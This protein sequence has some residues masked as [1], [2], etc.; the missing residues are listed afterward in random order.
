MSGKSTAVATKPLTQKQ[1]EARSKQAF[2]LERSIKKAAVLAHASWWALAELLYKFHEGGYWTD[3]GYDSLDEFLAQPEIGISRAQFFKQSKVWRDLVVVKKIKP[4]ELEALEPAK[5][6]EV[7]PAIM[8]GEV[9][10]KDALD[11][12][13]ELSFRDVKIKYRPEERG[14]HGQSPD[15]STPL[16]ADAEPEVVKCAVCGSWYT[17]GKPDIQGNATEVQNGD[18]EAGN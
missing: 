13:Q 15:D 12:A 11:D 17:P 2:N 6:A 9:K 14:K 3:L 4:K 1:I 10:P 5:V 7:V 16:D 8:R 18:G